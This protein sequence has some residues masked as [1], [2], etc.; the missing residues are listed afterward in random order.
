M[1]AHI[2][3]HQKLHTRTEDFQRI[4]DTAV[5]KTRNFGRAFLPSQAQV[6]R[7]P[8]LNPI[9][10]TRT[11]LILSS[12]KLEPES[13]DG[14]DLPLTNAVITARVF[15]ALSHFCLPSAKTSHMYREHG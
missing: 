11:H 15:D 12:G 10:T 14:L 7:A 5:F 3:S 9:L 13:V 1:P 6:S 8:A 4:E 2:V